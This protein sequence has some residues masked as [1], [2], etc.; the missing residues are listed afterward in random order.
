MRRALAILWL[1]SLSSC[2]I[3]DGKQ[4]VDDP[5]F[6]PKLSDALQNALEKA[7]ITQKADSISASL[8]ISDRCH[9]EG[10]TGVTRPD[11]GVPVES[12]MLFGFGS[13]TKTFVAAIIMQL[14][15]EN[16][17][18]L[19]DPLGKWLEKRP[20]IDSNITIRQLLNHGS[21]LYDYTYNSSYWSDIEANPNRV[22]PPEDV[23]KYVKPPPNLGFD[24]ARYSNTN[25]TLLG[26]IIESVTGSSLEQELQHRIIG[27]VQLDSTYLAKND[28]NKKRWANSTA[29]FSST[30]SSTWA[31]GAIAST[32]KDIAKWSHVLYSG[33][34]LQTTSLDSMLVTE[35]RRV[36]QRWMSVGLGVMKLNAGAQSA[37]GHQGRF[38]PFVSETFYIPKFEFSVA[39]VSS[40]A[41][42]SIRDVAG[43]DLV[44]AY[45]NNRPDNISVC[46]EV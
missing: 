41:D 13:I 21:G 42:L 36:R 22:W 29:L 45:L 28:F 2:T 31:G 35:D 14:V 24:V 30:Y 15:E 19:D 38:D 23:L 16:R 12:D 8:Y 9:W 4:Y 5:V 3:F 20:N 1:I 46:F 37:W 25:Y 33:N 18:G 7:A 39:F 43:I 10:A 34:F 27:P 11:P 44:L 32:S 17:L 40:E 6:N 26:M